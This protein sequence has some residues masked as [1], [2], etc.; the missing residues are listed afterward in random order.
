MQKKF[1]INQ[2]MIK[3]GF[4][5]G[6]KVVNHNSKSD[7]PL[8]QKQDLTFKLNVFLAFFTLA[9]WELLYLVTLMSVLSI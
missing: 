2:T 3:G 5:L 4:Q 9:I 7:F 1:E 8:V 6:R